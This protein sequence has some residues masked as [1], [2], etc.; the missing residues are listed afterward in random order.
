MP[1]LA[2]RFQPLTAAGGKALLPYITAGYPDCESTLA[3]LRG[4]P[5]GACAAVELGIPFSDPIADGPVIQMSFA[6][7]LAAGFRLDVLFAAL[8]GARNEIG[9]P[10]IAMV[11]YSIVHRRGVERFIDQAVAAGI[12]GLIIP[13]LGLEAAGPLAAA[14]RERNCPLVLIVAPTT[15]PQ[16]RQQIAT[17]SEPFVYYQA[18]A[19][20]TGE[21]TG[22]P[23]DLAASVR[24]LRAAAGKPV[25]VGFGISR[26][27]H[28]AAVCEVADGAIV[29]S[30]IVR[31]MNDAVDRGGRGPAVAAEVAAFVQE[32]AAPLSGR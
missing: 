29:G 26:P 17:L 14:A 23:P 7:A 20:V 22:L 12:D 6:R 28:V 16:R 13:D 3:I 9:I 18:V 25:C 19:G 4:L 15:A 24:S 31:R 2:D 27:E 10:L 5:R 32:L 1:R 11:S 8:R 30:A 21:R